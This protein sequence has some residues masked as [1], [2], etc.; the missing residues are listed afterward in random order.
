MELDV[1]HLRLVLAVAD[2][3]SLSAAARALG[4][5]QPTVSNQLRRIEESAGG[6]LFV[7]STHGVAPTERGRALLRRAR[8]IV[9]Q[10]DRIGAAAVPRSSP[11]TVRVRTFVLPFAL[12]LPLAQWLVPGTRW[13]MSAGSPDDG[14]AAVADGL[15]DLYFGL[16][17]DDPVPAG[18]VVEEVLRERS[19][20]V[21][22]TGHRL[23]GEPVIELAALA[24][25][26]WGSRREPEV[27]RALM[28]QCRRAGFEPD[29]RFRAA[30]T[31]S[32]MALVASGAAI[33]L[34]SPVADPGAPVTMRPC[35]DTTS[36]AWILVYRAGGLTPEFVRTV[37]D[38]VRWSYTSKAH[39]NPELM[40]I[41]PPGLAAAQLPSPLAPAAR[42]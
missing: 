41:M 11:A 12:M 29:V 34:T 28:V 25:E 35:S 33:A 17:W 22:S 3:G 13:E 4:V 6:A 39:H 2:A 18:L 30:D 5:A 40:S 20:V 7:R 32:L 14:I 1:R 27:V 31:G 23:A 19:W 8:S 26:V 36:H 42:T 38:L 21:M 15:A 16:H 37:A 24:G 10:V 9:D